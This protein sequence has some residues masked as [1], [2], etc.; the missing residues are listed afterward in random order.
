MD[1][2][3]HKNDHRPIYAD[4]KTL[5]QIEKAFTF[6]PAKPEQ[7]PIYTDAR[8]KAKE[9][10]LFFAENSPPSHELSLA[11]TKIEEAV[12]HFNAGVARNT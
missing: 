12:M 8:A 1:A 6:H 2:T 9:L 7:Q 4:A 10:A 3:D 5:A 11:L